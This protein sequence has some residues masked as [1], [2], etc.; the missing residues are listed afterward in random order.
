MDQNDE[1][2][3]LVQN[4]I[5]HNNTYIIL[6]LLS[7]EVHWYDYYRVSHVLWFLRDILFHVNL[8]RQDGYAKSVAD[9]TTVF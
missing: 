7:I 1:N 5:L 3:N 6:V 2:R 9:L 4:V 8:G